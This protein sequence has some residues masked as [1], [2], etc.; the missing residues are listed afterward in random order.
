[1]DVLRYVFLEQ[2]YV[3]IPLL[4]IGTYICLVVWLRRR[5]PRAK[6]ALL[7]A[8]LLCVTLP[9]VQWLVVTD[10]EQIRAV[11]ESIGRAVEAGDVDAISRHVAADFRTRDIDRAELLDMAERALAR[12]HPQNVRFRDFRVDVDGD[13]A[14]VTYTSICSVSGEYIERDVRVNWIAIFIRVNGEWHLQSA[15]IRQTPFL[16]ISRLEDLR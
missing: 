12:H 16:P 6:R 10:R 14:E 1:M 2:P 5:T 7:I 8:L 11:C 13:R 3:L 15:D 9:L 4:V